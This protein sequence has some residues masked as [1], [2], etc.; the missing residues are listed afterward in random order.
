MA[1]I[2][3]VN[4]A[5]YD[6]SRVYD[7][8]AELVKDVYHVLNDYGCTD[9]S[10]NTNTPFEAF[11]GLEKAVDENTMRPYFAAK[12]SFTKTVQVCE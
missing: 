9:I 3:W 4:L 8:G 10:I 2:F 7:Y 11:S 1:L 12:L 5:K 6:P